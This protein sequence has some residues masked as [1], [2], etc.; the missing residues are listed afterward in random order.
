MVR[1][2]DLNFPPVESIQYSEPENTYRAC[3]QQVSYVPP[4]SATNIE[5]TE[6]EVVILSSSGSLPMGRNITKRNHSVMMNLNQDLE[7]NLRRSVTSEEHVRSPSCI[8]CKR[9][10]RSS[11]S[12][13][14]ANYYPYHDLEDGHDARSKKLVTP[15]PLVKVIVKPH[16]CSICMEELVEAASTICGH[17]F[18]VTCTKSFIRIQKKCPTCRRKLNMRNFHRVYLPN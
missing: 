16:T 11:T 12:G 4:S 7:L 5:L 15:E 6:N 10:F 18:C 1:N 2:I 9:P 8:A 13:T 14:T 3:Q 17:I